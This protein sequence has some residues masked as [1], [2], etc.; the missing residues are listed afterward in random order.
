MYTNF[1]NESMSQ[2]LRA[3]ALFFKRMYELGCQQQLNALEKVHDA[4]MSSQQDLTQSMNAAMNPGD[5]ASV[6][7]LMTSMPLWAMR[8]QMR[9]GQKVMEL[10]SHAFEDLGK[11]VR[12]AFT[13]WQKEV[14]GALQVGNSLQPAR[15]TAQSQ[16]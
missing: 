5:G 12:E 10:N 9:Q 16:T 3:N 1:S 14:N 11:P 4:L 2:M 15:A 8:T 7:K 13:D 6:A